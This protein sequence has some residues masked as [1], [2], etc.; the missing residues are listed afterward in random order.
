[1]P[2]I[3]LLEELW[4]CNLVKQAA[5]TVVLPWPYVYELDKED[6][7]LLGIPQPDDRFFGKLQT[8][9]WPTKRD[10]R[11]WV[12]L[13]VSDATGYHLLPA[14]QRTGLLFETPQG[15]ALPPRPIGELVLLLD[16]QL[17]KAVSDRTLRIAEAKRL[18]RQ[19]K[20]VALDD[21][22][23]R[24]E[25]IVPDGISVGVEVT[26]PEEIKLS[27][28]A[29]GVDESDFPSFSDGPAKSVYTQFLAAGGRRRLVLRQD[30]REAVR[31]L[32]GNAILSGPD[33]PRFFDNPEAF[34]PDAVDVELAH[35]S[36]RVRGLI[37]V[38]Y[39][40][41]PYISVTRAKRRGWFDA[42]PSVEITEQAGE[43]ELGTSDEQL[44]E[45]MSPEE[46][47]ELA[48]QSIASG[49]RYVRYRNG[50]MEVDPERAKRFLEFC[51]DHPDTDGD[52]KRRIEEREVQLVL[53]VISNTEVLEYDESDDESTPLPK[54]PSYDAPQALR[55][56]LYPHQEVGYRWMRYLHENGWGGLL[57]D[58]MG[59]GKT[60]QLIAFMSHLHDC[61]RLK[62]ALLVVPLSVIVNWKKE[63]KRFAPGIEPAYEHRGPLRERDPVRLA[64]HELVITTY[65][66][67]RR[68]QL[69]LGKV[70]WMFVACDEAQNVKNPT[71]NVT[72]AIKGMKA[73]FRIACTGTP[74][75][76]GLSELWCIMDFAQPGRLGSGAEFRDE[77]ERPLVDALDQDGDES[78]HVARLRAR[79]NPHY[80]RRTKEAVLALPPKNARTYRVPMSERQAALYS[81]IQGGVKDGTIMA[82][83]GL[84]RLIAVCSHPAIV[85]QGPDLPDVDRLLRDAPKLRRTMDILD[86]VRTLGEKAVVYTRFKIMQRIIQAVVTSRFGF[87][88]SVLNGE[89]AG[90]NRHEIVEAFNRGSRFDLLILSPEAAGV[91][92]NITGATHVIHYTR[93]WN[94]AK[95]NQ[96]TDRVHRIGQDRPVTVHYPVVEGRGSKSVEEHLHDLLE[97]KLRLARNVLIPRK[98][99]D[100]VNEL[101]RRV[102]AEE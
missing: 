38:R 14:D 76:N 102:R 18:A 29:R 97:E 67:L 88:P 79:L 95:E 64:Q 34:L 101:G 41:Q 31:H 7:D 80:V 3:R 21:F 25:H 87:H 86:E 32:Q 33:V 27:P 83:A 43:E 12:E 54:L 92:L 75:E 23:K 17:P 30:Q 24:E 98:S 53:D 72:S 99:L 65:A 91:G 56:T 39:R 60:V 61:G 2:V 47:R 69:M 10:F 71:A 70:D 36:D 78:G 26:S 16:E 52:G 55:A 4:G 13:H 5:S 77:F 85:D 9:L 58:D 59:L 28:T 6:R 62:P 42:S 57:A 22:L 100:F 73:S 46:F 63:L 19:S 74:V 44:A 48:E 51:D 20:R 8:Y 15:P 82:L 35:F 68:D 45:E 11:L 66:T 94:P 37:P 1:M 49:E 40:S 89:V 96:A 81:Q 90:L 50:W 93:L 84:Q